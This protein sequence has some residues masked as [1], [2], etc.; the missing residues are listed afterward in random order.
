MQPVTV[1]FSLTALVGSVVYAATQPP[2]QPPAEALAACASKAV[3]TQC[4]VQL[5]DRTLQGS[6]QQVP[7]GQTACVPQGMPPMNGGNG[8]MQPPANN[9]A[10]MGGDMGGGM[11]GGLH[12]HTI[13]QSSGK[14]TLIPA[15]QDPITNSTITVTTSGNQRVIVANGISKHRTGKFPNAGNPNSISVQSYTFKIPLNPKLTGQIKNIG[16]NNFGIAVNGVTFDPTAAETYKG[17]R[18]WTYEAMSGA[19]PLGVDANH[20]HVQP[21]GAYHYHAKPT[22]LLQSLGVSASKHSPLV[23]W[24]AD[25]FPIYALYGYQANSKQVIPVSSSYRLKQGQRPKGGTNPG[26]TY[27]GTF[28]NDYEYVQGAGNLD[29]CN[30]RMTS[31]PEFPQGTYAYFITN[32][33]PMIPR[34][35]KGS[36]SSDFMHRLPGMRPNG[37]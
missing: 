24:A 36:P 18:T 2:R 16:L 28:L 25:G 22:L 15:T 17:D 32:E 35:F 13:N 12:S 29:E 14:V 4:S 7:S 1:L 19:I 31:T 33:Y 30:G 37:G 8:T 5:P 11:G 21:T 3:G 26:G 34:C 9:G 23:G 10:G 20:A 6:C 27:D